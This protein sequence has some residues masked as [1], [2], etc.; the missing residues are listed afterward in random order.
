M[1]DWD[2]PEDD[3]EEAFNWSFNRKLRTRIRFKRLLASRWRWATWV[4]SN[5]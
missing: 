1:T 2:F 4:S 5:G 3:A